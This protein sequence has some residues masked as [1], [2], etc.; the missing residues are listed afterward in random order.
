M[1]S[2][3]WCFGHYGIAGNS[4]C[5]WKKDTNKHT[6]KY[7]FNEGIYMDGQIVSDTV[8]QAQRSS[9]SERNIGIFASIK[10]TTP[11]YSVGLRIY[12]C[13]FYE[14]NDVLVRNFVPCYRKLDKV[15]GLYDIVNGVFYTNAGTGEFV[16]GAEAEIDEGMGD[17]VSDTSDPNYDKYKI[18][19][20]I[21]NE[22]GES[23]KN[24]I[25]M[26]EPLY[27]GEY[28]DYKSQKIFRNNGTQES[29]SL[30]EISIYE[31]YTKIE[32][33]TEITP[34]KIEVEYTGYII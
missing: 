8:V 25:I 2:T 34:S 6:V 17:L 13:K 4:L 22:Q 28:I 7:I 20:K 15:A 12:N 10:G 21:N 27:D 30:P 19:I 11:N 33:L 32:V 9:I 14:A 3:K 26:N 23:V 29:I 16:V 5:F 31:D 24:D 1:D 18:S